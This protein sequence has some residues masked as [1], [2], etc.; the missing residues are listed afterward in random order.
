[1]LDYLAFVLELQCPKKVKVFGT[2]SLR[3]ALIFC[4]YRRRIGGELDTELG[5]SWVGMNEER[6]RGVE[7][8]KWSS[9]SE[10]IRETNKI[11]CSSQTK[12]VSSTVFH[13]HSSMFSEMTS[14]LLPPLSLLLFRWTHTNPASAQTLFTIEGI[15][16]TVLPAC[17]PSL[18]SANTVLSFP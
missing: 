6:G 17:L 9:Y 14:C 13:F 10:M 7:Y 15:A 12:T 2:V 4:S 8:M 5:L 1:M 18:P 3:D 16:N 11:L